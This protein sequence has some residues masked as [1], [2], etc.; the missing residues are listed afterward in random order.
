[1]GSDQTA[2]EVPCPARRIVLT[3]VGSLGDL[4][5]DIAIAVGLK[6]RGH[7]P[8]LATSPCYRPKVQALGLGFQAGTPAWFPRR[9]FPL[10]RRDY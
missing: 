9:V 5:P 7:E 1:M 3:A 2:T 8:I 4:H 6:A 10:G